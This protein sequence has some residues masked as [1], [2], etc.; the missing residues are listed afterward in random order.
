MPLITWAF[1]GYAGGLLAGF[2]GYVVPAAGCALPMACATAVRRGAL[3]FVATLF[4]C[5]VVTAVVTPPPPPPWERSPGAL[6]PVRS[7]LGERIDRLFGS[8]AHIARALL[9]ADQKQMAVEVR[10]RYATAGLVHMLSI[11]GLHVAIIASSLELLLLT[12]RF[13]RRHA[14]ALSVLLVFAY[15]AVLDWRAPA[16]RA[17]VM[18]GTISLSRAVQRP[19][20]PWATLAIGGWIP[21]VSPRTVME[22]G[23]QLSLCGMAALTAA[24]IIARRLKL[25][26][27]GPVK[28]RVLRD[29]LAS[30]L[31]SL[32]TAP[33]VAWYF[34]RVSLIGPVANLVAGPVISILQ[35]T[36]FL[37][38]ALAGD[39]G[40]ARFVAG[41]ARPLLRAFDSVAR[42]ASDLPFAALD[43]APTL[44]MTV[45]LSVGVVAVLVAA[46]GRRPGPPLKLGLAVLA[47]A[48]WV[49]LLPSR[50]RDVEL[51]V[52]D[53][54][55]GDAIALRTDRGNW[56]LFDAGRT[57]RR[58]DA[59]RSVVVPYV[60]RR[61]GNVHA[62]VMS[63]P[64]ADHVGGGASVLRWLKPRSVWDPAFPGPTASYRDALALAAQRSIRW[65]RVTPGDSIAADGVAI[66][67]LA[68]DSAWTASLSD[69]NEASAVALVTFGSV[70]FLLTGDAE[71]ALES[72]LIFN[73]GHL[74]DVDVLKVAHHGSR[75]SSTE[76]FLDATTPRLA[77][78]SVGA[79]NAYAH[80]SPEVESRLDA[81]GIRT[82]RTDRGG[83]VMVR[84]DGRRL[85]V[86]QGGSE[87]ELQPQ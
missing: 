20:S 9:I 35:P 82:V 31:A 62:F 70:K 8:D 37:A 29:L 60:R 61:G 19:T 10:E 63:H 74:L 3:F 66:T 53:V 21:L 36:L 16:F 58:G 2:W 47:L 44:A 1:L 86:S 51:H 49:P 28:S 25:D 87:W 30:T 50:V 83:T 80:P 64:H 73:A 27:L 26:E 59:G 42:T 13:R 39:H 18:Y 12:L 77:I 57:W 32:V 79:E 81:R 55:Q 5:G 22:L 17:A 71:H 78:I 65:R 43:S 46:S 54:G 11:S 56:V 72:W 52:L 14:A 45:A 85:V 84:T 76:E 69:P 7:R 48:A 38:L 6:E 33:L 23:Y 40:A 24:G 68:P 15:V 4:L 75:T 67:F 41:A 34:G